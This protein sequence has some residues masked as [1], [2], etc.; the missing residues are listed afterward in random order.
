M[1]L[2]RQPTISSITSGFKDAVTSDNEGPALVVARSTCDSSIDQTTTS[3][4]TDIDM[5]YL[6]QV[7]L[8]SVGAEPCATQKTKQPITQT[9]TTELKC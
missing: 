5:L 4:A 6:L 1:T 9:L 8:V 2:R 3:N 7:F